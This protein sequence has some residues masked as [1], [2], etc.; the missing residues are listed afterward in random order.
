MSEWYLIIKYKRI[1]V[2]YIYCFRNIVDAFTSR[3]FINSLPKYVSSYR[4]DSSVDP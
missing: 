3:S 2:Y 4:L 1:R